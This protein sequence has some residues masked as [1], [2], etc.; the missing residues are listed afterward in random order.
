MIFHIV[1]QVVPF[2]AALLLYRFFVVPAVR[3]VRARAIWLMAMLLPA[4]K[5]VVFAAFGGNAFAPE[6]PEKL[7]WFWNWAYS[8]MMILCAFAEPKC[9][10]I[11]T[12]ISMTGSGAGTSLSPQTSP[13]AR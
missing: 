9:A 3:G 1:F 7:I 4:S 8:G 12:N 5:F 13:R 2:I 11:P 10:I 6:L